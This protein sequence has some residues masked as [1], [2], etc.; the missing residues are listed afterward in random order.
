MTTNDDMLVFAECVT[1]GG[2]T[3]EMIPRRELAT[4]RAK[5]VVCTPIDMRPWVYDSNSATY[6]R[7]D[8]NDHLVDDDDAD[9]R[10]E[11]RCQSCGYALFNAIITR[12]CLVA[13]EVR[14]YAETDVD[15][16]YNYVAAIRPRREPNTIENEE[17]VDDPL[18]PLEQDEID[19]VAWSCAACGEPYDGPVVTV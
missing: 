16:N 9:E 17:Y 6:T 2:L 12:T 11:G 15:T 14:L 7:H 5:C 4:S 3:D 19:D 18:G 13:Y 1:C 8:D 10:E